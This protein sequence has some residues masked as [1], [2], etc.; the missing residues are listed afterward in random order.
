MT[1]T[2]PS[3]WPPY[4]PDSDAAGAADEPFVPVPAGLL[5]DAAKLL[6]VFEL[7]VDHP[8]RS[9]CVS[10]HLRDALRHRGAADPAAA[11]S[12]LT[13]STG[14]ASRALYASLDETGITV[15]DTS[16][17]LDHITRRRPG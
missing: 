6:A 15:D 5:A 14:P 7:L 17:Y 9:R 16:P 11:M 1:P 12:W 4:D 10:A 13:R 2:D 3:S 8:G